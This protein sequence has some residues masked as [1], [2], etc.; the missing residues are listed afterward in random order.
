MNIVN[1]NNVFSLGLNILNKYR[2]YKDNVRRNG[3]PKIQHDTIIDVFG[4]KS[5]ILRVNYNKI[6]TVV[7]NI[8]NN[9]APYNIPETSKDYINKRQFNNV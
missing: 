5:K 1:L 3:S 8:L 9:F 4:V 2:I 7:N 6:L